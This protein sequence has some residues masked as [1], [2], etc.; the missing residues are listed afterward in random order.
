MRAPS[1]TA[2]GPSRSAV[3]K[4]PRVRRRELIFGRFSQPTGSTAVRGSP[5]TACGPE[6]PAGGVWRWRHSVAQPSVLGQVAQPRELIRRWRHFMLAG[7]NSGCDLSGAGGSAHDFDELV[8]GG[9]CGSVS[10]PSDDGRGHAI[11]RARS[12]LGHRVPCASCF[13]AQVSESSWRNTCRRATIART[14]GGGQPDF[15]QAWAVP[16]RMCST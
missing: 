12:H 4:R 10:V 8:V 16:A 1:A 5:P 14:R 2:P 13:G 6:Y 9:P 15:G 7:A 11:H 3:A